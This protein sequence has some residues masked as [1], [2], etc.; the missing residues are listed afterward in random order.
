[1]SDNIERHKELSK[2]VLIPDEPKTP[3]QKA[4]SRIPL[5]PIQLL[6]PFSLGAI[7]GF[8]IFVAIWIIAGFSKLAVMLPFMGGF[9]GVAIEIIRR[10]T[11][12]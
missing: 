3:E 2:R 9:S 4:S 7:T 10:K 11:K 8:F 12:A 5:A 6:Y 1:M